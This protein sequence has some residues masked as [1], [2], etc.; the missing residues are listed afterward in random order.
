MLSGRGYMVTAVIV[1]LVFA[2]L[3][4]FFGPNLT[5]FVNQTMNGA[6]PYIGS[7]TLLI[8]EPLKLVFANPLVGSAIL[9]LFWPLGAVIVALFFVM[10]L[11]ALGG[12]TVLNLGNSVQG[13]TR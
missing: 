3:G 11:I 1:F 5:S 2:G 8:G 9:A 6:N 7:L 4:Y 10:M 13:L 12:G